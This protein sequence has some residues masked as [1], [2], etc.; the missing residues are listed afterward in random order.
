TLPCEVAGQFYPQRDLDWYQ[1]EA[2]QGEVWSIEVYSERLGLPTDPAFLLQRLTT[3]ESG[4]QQVSDI[5]FLDDLQEQNFNNRSG[6]HEF[7]MRT[8]D[9]SYIFSVPADGTYRLMLKDGYGSVKTDPRLVYRLAIRK[10]AQDFRIVAVPGDSTGSL[11]LRKGGRD[12]VRVFVD[13]QDGFAGEIRVSATGLPSGV[14]T[15]EI[16]IGPANSMGTLILTAEQD[17]PASTGTINVLAKATVDGKEI[18]RKA[19]YGAAL[20]PFQFNQPNANVPSVPGRL[21]ERI[22]VCVSD[23]E[24]APQVLTIGDGKVIES[25]RGG[26]VK[27]P[28]QVT[29]LEGTGGNLI[30]FPID[31]PPQTNAQQ[32]GIGGNEKGEFELRFT[33]NT[34]PG[35]YTIYLAGFNQG[36]QYKRNPELAARAKERQERI[37]K[38]L[39]EAQQKTQQAQ[40]LVQQRQ[41]E[42][43]QANTALNQANTAR[44]QADQAAA[45]ATNDLQQAEAVLKQ[46]QEAAAANPAD[47]G[48]KTKVTQAVAARDEAMKKSKEADTL[49]SDAA[50]KQQEATVAQQAAMEAK[51]RADMEFQAAQQFQQQAQQEKQRA[52]QFANQK[53]NEA[54][55][56]GLNVNVPSN[57]VTLRIVEFPINVDALP[58]V[59]SVKQGEKA[60]VVTKISRQYEF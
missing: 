36:L 24:P 11:M 8:T 38:I 50:K 54:N 17:A 46:V 26:V 20:M 6:R 31:F 33:S 25:S 1:F 51:T 18:T 39:M 7:D 21:V 49:A 22:Q 37:G 13:R 59:V 53:Q 42:L 15:E 57:P 60:E 2:K 52:D 47:E 19:R 28:Y 48:L 55:P 43:N 40:Q 14:S 5:V 9:P 27:I 35:T 45:K 23:S 34:P 4:E 12:V 29:R 58:E 41:N 56:R 16:I 10:P 44:Q 3:A 30:G 32:I